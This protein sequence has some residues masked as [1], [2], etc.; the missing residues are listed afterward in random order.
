[1]NKF[2]GKK[3]KIKKYNICELLDS[4]PYRERKK[5]R[6]KLIQTMNV[7]NST[8]ER[9]LYA[10]VGSEQKLD[11]INLLKVARFFDVSPEQIV[12][13]IELEHIYSD[14]AQVV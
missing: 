1:M 14:V 5:A 10:E 3:G 9:I 6:K 8:F 12:N 4:L 2:K 11:S 7:S 13:N